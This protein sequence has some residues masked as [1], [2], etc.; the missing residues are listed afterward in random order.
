MNFI[1][2][3]SQLSPRIIRILGCNPGPF[4]LQG[5][6]TYLIGTGK[7]RILLDT[8]DGQVPEYFDLLQS[9][10]KEHQ[11]T[12]DQIILT[13]W[14]PDHVGG[15]ETIQQSINKD[16]KIYKFPI[17][18]KSTAEE[19]KFEV[20]SDGQQLTTEGA[21]LKVYH[22]PGHTTDHVI[23]HLI[24][25]NALF[26]GDC[27]LGE[28]TAV[29]EDLHD[30]MNS[31]KTILNIEPA[32]I[33]PGHGPTVEDPIQK[34]QYYIHHRNER[35][36]QILEFLTSAN[37]KCTPMDIVKGIYIDLDPSLYLAAERNVELHLKKLQKEGKVKNTATTL[38]NSL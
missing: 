38:W 27:I 24:E 9:V 10:L 19:R 35:E 31:L 3:I 37:W 14:H 22:T 12:L 5:T 29:F 21:Q 28:G 33:Y 16:C 13:H 8:G 17:A 2:R 7:R 4:T 15:V 6:N 20:L 36:N 34:I 30:Y 25:E 1:P 23:L 32:I 11:V 26:S 18:D